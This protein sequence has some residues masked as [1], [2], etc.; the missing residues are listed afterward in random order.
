MGAASD[1]GRL[2]IAFSADRGYRERLLEELSG[3]Q[4][5]SSEV[6]FYSTTT[7]ALL[8]TS[9]LDAEYWYQNL[10]QTVQFESATRAFLIVVLGCLLR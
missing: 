8:D 1:T 9:K 5:R 6:P 2:R 4:P 10:R 7:G 3:I